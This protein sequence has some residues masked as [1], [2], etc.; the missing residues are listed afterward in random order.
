LEIRSIA[1]NAVSM[2]KDMLF[3]NKLNFL[4]KGKTQASEDQSKLFI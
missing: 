3:D 2:D 4:E 1:I